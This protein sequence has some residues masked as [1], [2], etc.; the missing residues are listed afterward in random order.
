VLDSLVAS[1]SN[2]IRIQATTALPEATI[3]YSRNPGVER[4]AEVYD[5]QPQWVLYV[6]YVSLLLFWI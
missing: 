2:A 5:K 6:A 4:D 1:R 3:L